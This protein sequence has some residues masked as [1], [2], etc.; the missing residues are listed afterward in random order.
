MQFSDVA[1]ISPQNGRSSGRSAI[2]ARSPV[3]VRFDHSSMIGRKICAADSPNSCSV[4]VLRAFAERFEPV[5]AEIVAAPLHVGGG[6]RH[7]ER[8]AKHREVLEVDLLL[9]ILRAG[10]DEHALAAENGGHEIGERLARARA[11]FDEQHAA[12]LERAGHRFGHLR[13]ARDGSRR[14]AA[15]RGERSRVG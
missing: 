14:W 1:A 11:G 6:E 8:L 13:A 5:Q 7:V 10:G 15:T 2:S 3:S 12:M 4:A 9:K